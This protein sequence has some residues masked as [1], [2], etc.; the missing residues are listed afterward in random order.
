M[1]RKWI[2]MLKGNMSSTRA[3]FMM[4]YQSY[5]GTRDETITR[6]QIDTFMAQ[7][8]PGQIGPSGQALKHPS[9]LTNSN[10]YRDSRGTYVLPWADLDAYLADNPNA[11]PATILARQSKKTQTESTT[12]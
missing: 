8:T 2:T 5:A 9:W 3:N 6:K 10:Q 7:L 1:Q 11:T 4:A 12:V